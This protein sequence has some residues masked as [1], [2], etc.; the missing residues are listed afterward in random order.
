MCTSRS[1]MQKKYLDQIMELYDDMH[2]VIQ[3]LQNE[4]VRGTDQ[5]KAFSQ[6][7]LQ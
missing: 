7:L 6:L 5:L 1:K 2:V 3:P 4:E